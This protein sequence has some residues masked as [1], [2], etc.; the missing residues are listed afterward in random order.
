MALFPI[1]IAKTLKWEGDSGQVT[2]DTGGLTKYGISQK[3]YPKADIAAL[4]KDQA[5]ALYFRDYWQA[6][7]LDQIN[8]QTLANA[9]F[10]FAVNAGKK[11]AVQKLQIALNQYSK[12]KLAVDGLIGL[13]TIAAANLAAPSFA[14]QYNKSREEFYKTLAVMDSEKYGKYLKGW[15]NRT[16]DFFSYSMSF[17][18]FAFTVAAFAGTWIFLKAKK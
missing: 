14:N 12:A 10:D 18:A 15:L 5:I 9:I 6:L 7:K 2:S 3:A 16:K 11:T 17:K 4:T 8:D 13:K 1:A